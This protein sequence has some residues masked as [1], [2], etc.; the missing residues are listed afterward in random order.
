VP[1]LSIDLSND[2]HRRFSVACAERGVSKSEVV[3]RLLEEWLGRC[4]VEEEVAEG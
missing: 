3:R 2:L 1:R 4:E